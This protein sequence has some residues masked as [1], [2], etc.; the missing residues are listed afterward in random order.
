MASDLPDRPHLEQGSIPPYQQIELWLCE[1]IAGGHLQGGDRLPPERE[2]AEELGVSRMTLRHALST[3]EARGLVIK[4]IGRNGGTF[5][6]GPKIA[7][8]L[9]SFAGFTE[10]LKNN[11][12][13]PGARIL[14][15]IE[16]PASD[17]LVKAF[18]IAPGAPCF[19]IERLRLADETP[20]AVERSWFPAERFP[21][22]IDH[23]LSS[24]L[25]A[26]LDRFYGQRPTRA[27][28]TLES[29]R[30]SNADARLLGLSR[31]QPA[32]QIERIAYSLTG[33]AVEYA[34]DIF[35]GDRTK[36]TL[37]SGV[38]PAL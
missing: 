23:D 19:R 6:Q 14:T 13:R 36:I 15:A 10:Q 32:L 21:G 4:T 24:S 9:S 12:M 20:V 18:E 37:W 26:I 17:E 1:A 31:T 30:L 29:I 16:Q 5:I 38:S 3:L 7:C 25:Y 28:E 2:L 22:L 34:R 33:E 11:G 8:D 27:L 35:L